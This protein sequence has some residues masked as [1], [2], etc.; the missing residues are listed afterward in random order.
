MGAPS[1]RVILLL[2]LV[3]L[4]PHFLLRLRGGRGVNEDLK[5]K[6]GGD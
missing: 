5:Y 4:L 2:P 6:S 1:Q 3:L